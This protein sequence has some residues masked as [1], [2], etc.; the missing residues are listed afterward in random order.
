MNEFKICA[1]CREYCRTQTGPHAWTH[2]CRLKQSDFPNADLCAAYQPPPTPQ[3]DRGLGYI[4]D[5]EYEGT[6]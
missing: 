5:Q 2:D 6:P 4:W 3:Y 1:F